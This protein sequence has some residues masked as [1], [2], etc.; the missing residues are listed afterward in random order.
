MHVHTSTCILCAIPL[1]L[2]FTEF[3]YHILGPCWLLLFFYALNVSRTSSSV[4]AH[5]F[6]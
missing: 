1:L 4:K 5:N 3:A 2:L 6:S